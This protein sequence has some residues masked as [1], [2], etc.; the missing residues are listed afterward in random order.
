VS[1]VRVGNPPTERQRKLLFSLPAFETLTA[2]VSWVGAAVLFGVLNADVQ[3]IS[4]G[5]ALAGVVTCTLLYLLLEGHFRPVYALALAD[6]DL[7]ADRRDVWPRLML[8]WL[9]GSAVP[10]VAIGLSPLIS[11]APLGGSPGWPAWARRPAG[12]SC[13]SPRS[14]SPGR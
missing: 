11:P 8:S 4:V 1:W 7:P 3:R 14:R 5:I 6:A 2:L 9:L 12:S 10:L 13:R